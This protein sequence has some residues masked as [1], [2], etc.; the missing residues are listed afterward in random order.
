MEEPEFLVMQTIYIATFANRE[1]S[2]NTNNSDNND[3]IQDTKIPV[4]YRKLH[5]L[6]PRSQFTTRIS[7]FNLDISCD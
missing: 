7:K 6:P 4:R 5:K 2:T 1:Q 3:N